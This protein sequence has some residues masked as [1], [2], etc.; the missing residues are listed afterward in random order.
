MTGRVTFVPDDLMHDNVERR[1]HR[2]YRNQ[3][4]VV[5]FIMSMAGESTSEN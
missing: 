1:D 5:I 4:D 2:A 3:T